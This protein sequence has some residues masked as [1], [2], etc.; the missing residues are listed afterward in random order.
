MW[1]LETLKIRTYELWANLHDLLNC[2]YEYSSP[3]NDERFKAE[4]T[5]FGDITLRQ[6]WE[7]AYAHLKAKFLADAATDDAQYLIEGHLIE[8]PREEGWSDLAPAVISQMLMIPVAVDAL[9]RG[10]QKIRRYGCE[11]GAD[12]ARVQELLGDSL[13]GKIEPKQLELISTAQ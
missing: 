3:N 5:Q 10:Y 2:F 9:Y 11:Y 8:A 1:T 13:N 7:V 12:P 6:T 4:M